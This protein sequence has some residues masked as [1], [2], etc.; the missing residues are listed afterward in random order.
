[1]VLLYLRF[2]E[3]GAVALKYVGFLVVL[4]ADVF[5]VITWASSSSKETTVVHC[6]EAHKTSLDGMELHG[7][8]F[9]PADSRI[10]RTARTY[11]HI[12]TL[13]PPDDGLLAS[14]KH[15]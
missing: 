2:L 1:V 11:C 5:P 15:V 10:I 13:L 6:S 14:L 9:H 7:V 8:P 4:C 3:D 12:Y